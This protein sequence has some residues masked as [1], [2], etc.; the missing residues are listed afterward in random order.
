[1]VLLCAVLLE[2]G[3][4]MLLH[5]LSVREMVTG[6]AAQRIALR[7]D[8]AARVAATA[9]RPD[10]ARMMGS[11]SGD[12][13]ILNWVPD[14]VI[15][16]FSGS[17][18]PLGEMR[19][20]LTATTPRLAGERLRLSLL[21][22]AQAGRQDLLG[23]LRLTDGSF[24]TFRV[25][26]FLDAPL[27]P[28]IITMLHM[29][30]MGTVMLIALLMVSTLLRPLRD[31]A[32]AADATGRGEIGRVAPS[33]PDEVRRVATAFAAMQTRLVRMVE[34]HTEALI[35]VSHDLR[36]PIQR[37]RLR[38]SIIADDET[39]GEIERDLAD[40]ERFID[41]ALSY[42][43]SGQDEPRR[44]IDLGALLTTIVD[45]AADLG[46]GIGYD[47]PDNLPV[48]TRPVALRRTMDN[49]I[50]NARR[51]ADRITVTLEADTD[52]RI[53]VADN[54]PGIPA[55]RRG[56]ALTPFRRLDTPVSSGD[57]PVAGA[58]L[59]LPAAQ[60]TV[61]ALGGSLTLDDGPLGGLAVR[62]ILPHET[63]AP[64]A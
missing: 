21:P 35:A 15:T 8:S 17:L 32:A 46:V 59:G 58:G 11:L 19:D 45:D 30:L 23:A 40:M 61:E 13:L 44:L 2:L 12:G 31:L 5:R 41:S 20:R 18:E 39:R 47:G 6:D 37:L 27:S 22:S 28:A 56:D 14:T 53:T 54:G 16:D 64:A 3:G 4:N 62:I 25:Q 50:D 24:V 1:M 29:L 52:L 26:P 49:L 60:R 33:G 36:T 34:D 48:T 51:H 43:R 55:E 10:R 38:S 57:G 9:N 42:V 7:L 63:D